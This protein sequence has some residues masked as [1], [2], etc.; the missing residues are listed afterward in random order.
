[1]LMR[2]IRNQLICRICGCFIGLLLL[3]VPSVRADQAGLLQTDA[4]SISPL[5][6]LTITVYDVNDF[7]QITV[8]NPVGIVHTFSAPVQNNQATASYVPSY[9]AGTYQVYAQTTGP[10]PVTETDTFQV[11]KPSDSLSIQDWQ[12]DATEYVPGQD[13]TFTFDLEDSSASPL[14]DFSGQLSD[15]VTGS[16]SGRLS[17]L[18]KMIGIA[19]DGTATVRLFLFFDASGSSWSGIHAGTEVRIGLNNIDGSTPLDSQII[20]SSG[21]ENNDG[22]YLSSTLT[23]AL[24]T[25]YVDTSFGGTDRIAYLDFEVPPT[26]SISDILISVNYIKYYYN[27]GWNDRIYIRENYIDTT[28]S[29]MTLNTGFDF[30]TLGRF[31]IYLPMTPNENGLLYYGVHA[32]QAIGESHINGGSISE[33]SGTYTN[34]W[35]WEDYIDATA[36]FYIYTDKWG[37]SHD[38]DGPITLSSQGT[39]GQTLA[40]QDFSADKDAYF[41]GEAIDFSFSLVS[42]SNEAVTGFSGT[43]AD[44]L[45]GTTAGGMYILRKFLDAQPDGSSTARLYLYFDTTGQWSNIYAPTSVDISLYNKDGITPLT[46]D[47]GLTTGFLN[48]DANALSSTLAGNEWTITVSNSFAGADKI[49]YLDFDFPPGYSVSDV[50]FSVDY[51]IYHCNRSWADVIYITTAHVNQGGFPVNLNGDFE[52]TE[53]SSFSGLGKFPIKLPLNPNTSG[54]IFYGLDS[55]DI[56]E[57]NINYGSLSA[58]GNE[59][60][61]TFTWNDYLHTTAQVFAYA[62]GWQFDDQAVSAPVTLTLD[63]TPRELVASD[64]DLDNRGYTLNDTRQM[65][66][67]ITDGWDNPQND[68]SFKDPFSNSNNGK[69]SIVS[70]HVM[71]DPNGYYILRLLMYFDASG[72]SW[73]GI[74]AG[75]QVQMSLYGPDGK[76]GI[77]AGIQVV[78]GSSNAD[79][80]MATALT[81]TAGVYDWTVDVIQGFS[82]A[83]RQVW[84][85]FVMQEPQ[86]ASQVVY[87][88]E[89]IKY[90]N[91]RDFADSITIKNVTVGQGSFP[92]DYFNNYLFQTGDTFSSLGKFPL[93]LSLNPGAGSIFPKMVSTEMTE[94]D[95]SMSVSDGRYTYT[96]YMDESG[97]DYETKMCASR[98][99]YTNYEAVCSESIMLLF[100][101]EPRYLGGLETEPIMLGDT[102]Q[103][104]LH[105]H[106]FV[107]VNYDNVQYVSSDPNIQI[108]DNIATFQPLS[109]DDTVEDVIITASSIVDSNLVT[110]SN[111]FTLY[112]AECMTSNDC[113]NM[114]MPVTCDVYQC[115]T[116]E[117]QSSYR[118]NVQG[119]DLSVFNK[120]V[121]ISNPFPEPNEIVTICAEIYNTGTTN[122]YDV[123]TNFYL[124]DV[125]SVPIDSNSIIVLPTTYMDLPF[126]TNNACIQWTVPPDLVEGPHRIWV[127]IS[128]YYPLE[129]EEDMLSNNYATVDFFVPD[130]EMTATDPAA[131]GGCPPPPSLRLFESFP[132][133]APMELYNAAPQCRTMTMLIP[134]KV[135]VCES[136]TICGPVMG[137]ELGYWNTL[138]WP[139]WSGYCQE[140]NV[141][142]EFITDF[143]RTYEKIYGLSSQ[144]AASELPSWTDIPGLFEPPG[145]WGDGWLPCH[146]EPTMFWPNIMYTPGVMN[147]GCGGLCPVSAWDCGQG[148][149][150]QPRFSSPLYNAYEFKVYGGARRVTRCQTEIDYI[151]V[152]YQ[153]CYTPGDDTPIHIPFT[154]FAG[155]PSD[156]DG[157]GDGDDGGSYGPNGPA[158]PGSGP[159][160]GPPIEFD[161]AGPPTDPYGNALPFAV[162]FCSSGT[163]TSNEPSDILLITP[164]GGLPEAGV[165]LQKGWNQFSLLLEPL[166]SIADRRIP[167]K[168]GWNFFGYSSMTP[169]LWTDAI[170]EN[171]LEEKTIEQ[172]HAAG[173]IQGVVY[174][175]DYQT[176]LYKFIPGDDDFLRNKRAYWLYADQDDLTLKLPLAGGSME[177]AGVYWEDM[178]VVNGPDTLSVTEAADAGWIDTSAY[179]IDP[180]EGLYKSIPAD[181]NELYAWQGYWLRSN[182]NGLILLT[183]QQQVQQQQAMAQY[184][185]M[186]FPITET[187]V[188]MVEFSTA[189]GQ[190]APDF[191]LKTVDGQTASLEDYRGSDVLLVFGNTRCPYCSAR[192]PLLNQLQHEGAF[193]VIYVALGTTPSAAREFVDQKD[194]AFTV[195][196]DSSQF[197]GRL[198]GIRAIPEAFVIDP[199]GV[200]QQQTT[201]DG[202]VLWYLLEGKEVPDQLTKLYPEL[203]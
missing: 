193:D 134:I 46:G 115:V 29:G 52:F 101:G 86:S 145:G 189:V 199:Q 3:A 186:L 93:F 1:M 177:Q 191:T 47:I 14:S 27:T 83:D 169:L 2:R 198:Y 63:D 106:F 165:L 24:W 66:V 109:T 181:A 34:I 131:I 190:P 182:L 119:V 196:V 59:Y 195:L 127:E 6:T 68:L 99:G 12:C 164:N 154:P 41:P 144:G 166:E 100:T 139:S 159:N 156:S 184:E 75:T 73:S 8:T 121:T 112:A 124:D 74:Y 42:D 54:F 110:Q 82:G 25:V 80:Y 167:L 125:N 96:H 114:G 203:L 44:P 20:R 17:I 31:P 142:Q 90:N 13:L 126:R 7:C 51:I 168:S 92:T 132:I 171:G 103:K 160:N 143:I 200:I 91:N 117:G 88:V 79:G 108:T 58:N 146:P 133:S 123:V 70:Q 94:L 49:A 50:V 113:N 18:R 85:D 48:N 158:G 32:D 202:P 107:E 104:N 43:L 183:A 175:L 71:T 174:T 65:S 37:Y 197:A 201:T 22:G 130:P 176:E 57:N 161:I 87:A 152:P 30:S 163:G 118:A 135:Q 39:A 157:P 55:S 178:L 147:P 45:P 170:I 81:E 5:Q 35:Q 76:T 122:I 11:L 36:D 172:A 187:T 129:M 4:N 120:N 188:E 33:N 56:P 95:G 138:F 149:S 194:I 77:P 64:Y 136:E 102:W 89:Q 155:G 179:C 16:D 180:N 61:N 137:Y 78:E 67:T 28:G 148:V 19:P 9:L 21:F 69:L 162:S 62:D 150:F 141:P 140:F 185:T 97:K 116:F 60:H 38:Y 53:G 72:S 128:G 98:Y 173:W 84:L 23:D 10:V 192:I 105:D 15:T 153:I 40:L 26:H 111:P 151:E